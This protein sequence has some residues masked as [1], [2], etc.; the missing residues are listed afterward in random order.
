MAGGGLA[1]D[2]LQVGERH[3][4][5]CGSHCASSEDLA[6]HLKTWAAQCLM[7]WGALQPGV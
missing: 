2:L 1:A 3:L 6:L 5:A 4:Y 7:H